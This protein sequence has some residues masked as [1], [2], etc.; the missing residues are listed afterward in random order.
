MQ[1]DK[2]D[3]HWKWCFL[4]SFSYW[5]V[6]YV[7]VTKNGRRELVK[8]HGTSRLCD[9]ETI[10]PIY[11]NCVF[12]S[13]IIMNNS[14]CYKSFK[15]WSFETHKHINHCRHSVTLV[16]LIHHSTGSK[17]RPMGQTRKCRSQATI[18]QFIFLFSFPSIFVQYLID[19][20]SNR[21]VHNDTF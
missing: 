11:H 6:K 21:S 3:Q 18:F 14:E 8:N 12:F 10:F 4:S 2:L 13:M 5:Y 9:T 17:F 15:D 7:L 16:P 1:R 19:Y 20:F